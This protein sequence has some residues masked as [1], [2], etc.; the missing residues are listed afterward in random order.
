MNPKVMNRLTIF[1]ISETVIKIHK[2]LKLDLNPYLIENKS[3]FQKR[4]IISNSAKFREAIFKK[5]NHLCP[6]CDESLHNGEKV[7]LHHIKP[8][9]EGGVYSMSNIQP[10]HQICHI[11]ITHNKAK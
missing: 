7:E 5:Y 1:N 3:Y 10:L 9:K 8:A 11:S 2:L 6:I 4:I